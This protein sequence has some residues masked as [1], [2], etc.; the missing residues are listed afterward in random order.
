MFSVAVLAACLNFLSSFSLFEIS[1]PI[2]LITFASTNTPVGS[3]IQHQLS[4]PFQPS[5]EPLHFV[6]L[7]RSHCQRPPLFNSAL[8]TSGQIFSLLP[9]PT[10]GP[11]LTPSSQSCSSAPPSLI[12]DQNTVEWVLPAASTWGKHKPCSPGQPLQNRATFSP[13]FTQASMENYSHHPCP[14]FRQC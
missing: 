11:G 13:A 14:D 6:F 12:S 1:I 9:S 7:A 8:N 4:C 2:S 10:F 3:Q 5:K